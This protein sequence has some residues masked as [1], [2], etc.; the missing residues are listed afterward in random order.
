MSISIKTA[1]T[2]AGTD[3]SGGAGLHADLKTFAAH[4]VYGMGAVTAL[5]SQNTVGVRALKLCPARL[6]QDQIAAVFEDIPPD[7][8]KVG[9]I[10]SPSLAR[11]VA[12]TLERYS[13][14]NLVVDPV[15]VA[16]SGHALAKKGSVA[17]LIATLLDRLIPIAALV[18]PNVPEGEA[19]SGR[20]IR[21]RDGMLKA[22]AI[23]RSRTGCAV[24]LKGGHIGDT[25]DDLLLDADGERWFEGK[26]IDTKDTH[27]TGC[28]LSAAIASNL[29]N[30][31]SLEASARLAKEYLTGALGAG[32]RLGK[33]SG[34][35][36]HGWHGA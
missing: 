23:I 7:A 2:I 29:A 4:G 13:A 25:C 14:S 20:P 35:V 21:D 28:T 15:L 30:C 6:V 5:V 16:T 17:S 33:G 36:F 1:L 22:A 12:Q 27:G 34:P 26:R 24:L 19:L 18:T 31:H 8:V 32:L 11:A 3:P 9:M 10:G